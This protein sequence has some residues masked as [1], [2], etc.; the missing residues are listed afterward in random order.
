MAGFKSYHYKRDMQTLYE[1][2][3]LCT[4]DREQC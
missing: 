1:N 3:S 4:F 2:K